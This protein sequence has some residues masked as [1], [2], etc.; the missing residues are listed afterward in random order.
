MVVQGLH[1]VLESYKQHFTSYISKQ[2]T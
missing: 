2:Y 1:D